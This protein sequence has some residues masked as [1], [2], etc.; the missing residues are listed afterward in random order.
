MIY[1]KGNFNYYESNSH[2]EI[3]FNGDIYEV[4]LCTR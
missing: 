4:V 2:S 1:A 3:K